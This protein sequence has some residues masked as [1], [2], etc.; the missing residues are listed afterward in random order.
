MKPTLDEQDMTVYASDAQTIQEPYGS[1]YSQGVRVGRT[2]P[3]KWWNWLFK[4]ATSR[5][6][7]AYLD[8]L[9]LFTEATNLLLDVG[10]TPD[11]S[12]STQLSQAI[13][14]KADEQIE[15]YVSEN[16]LKEFKYW[17][18]TANNGLPTDT[19]SGNLIELENGT[20]LLG[21]RAV[22]AQP[23]YRFSTDGCENWEPFIYN[24]TSGGSYSI[25]PFCFCNGKYLF[26]TERTLAANT[27]SIQESEDIQGVRYPYNPVATINVTQPVSSDR[28]DIFYTIIGT[29]VYIMH[30]YG[31]LLK[32]DSVLKTLSDTGVTA[33][34][35]GLTPQTYTDGVGIHSVKA[36]QINGKYFVGSLVFDGTNWANACPTMDSSSFAPSPINVKPNT[37]LADGKIYFT[38]LQYYDPRTTVPLKVP[39]YDM[40]TGT[41]S[42]LPY[43]T[44]YN[45]VRDVLVCFKDFENGDF[46]PV[47]SYD[48]VNFTEI[49][50]TPPQ[51]NTYRQ[52]NLNVAQLSDGYLIAY[53]QY[54][55]TNNHIIYFYYIRGE[56]S[57]DLSKYEVRTQSNP[58]YAGTGFLV[59]G[60]EN[61][62]VC[63][64]AVLNDGGYERR[65]RVFDKGERLERLEFIGTPTPVF[66][67]P[68]YNVPLM[69]YIMKQPFSARSGYWQITVSKA[70]VNT[71]ADYTLYL[72]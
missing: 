26:I 5:L 42:V 33:Y 71:V 41:S 1:D 22:S 46:T 23:S 38:S 24:T 9:N 11:A 72:Q 21:Y 16:K 43:Y 56:L 52:F 55:S 54:T 36:V 53:H 19:Y 10:I 14:A 44:W 39:V 64:I 4:A 35:L 65:Y 63:F 28:Y 60:F 48:C 32:Y 62:D 18:L 25:T 7:Q 68:A 45:Q 12:D 67:R 70:S 34:S 3:A 58:Y 20:V 66:D 57:G 8:I 51:D 2:I 40:A 31:I 37:V 69:P 29:D 13:A 30:H 6:H 17:Y 61:S 59:R 27:V 49:P 15:V 50:I 47:F